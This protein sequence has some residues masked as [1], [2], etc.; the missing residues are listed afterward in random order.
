MANGTTN[1]GFFGKI[2]EFLKGNPIFAVLSSLLLLAFIMPP[3]SRKYRR[4]QKA[5][6]RRRRSGT[7]PV[8]STTVSRRKKEKK[9][10][11]SK[12]VISPRVR[13]KRASSTAKPPW[14][15]KGSAAA[16]AHMN[17]LRSL[18]KKT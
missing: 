7:T 10:K 4:K 2:I 5:A 9:T 14:M 18:R 3:R 15:V 1:T 12:K 6:R 16:K 17:R 8:K 13:T 11:K